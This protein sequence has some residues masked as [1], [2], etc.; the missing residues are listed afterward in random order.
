MLGLFRKRQS[1]KAF[2]GWDITSILSNYNI[3]ELIEL[4]KIFNQKAYDP[5]QIEKISKI[6]GFNIQEI[7]VFESISVDNMN[8]NILAYGNGLLIDVD[9]GINLEY[10]RVMDQE[11]PLQIIDE[12]FSF[13]K[14]QPMI[15]GN[16]SC[17]K[18]V[19]NPYWPKIQG[20][21]GERGVQIQ[22]VF[23]FYE[24]DIT[25]SLVN[26]KR[27]SAC[28]FRLTENGEATRIPNRFVDTH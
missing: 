22:H 7:A 8:Q 10:Y 11:P 1:L 12:A 28:L 25:V 13:I 2:R 9:A 20:M 17:S 15:I 23:R 6:L 5:E 4:Q 16:D 3:K 18:L 14:N 24:L 19:D 27:Q 21:M 26:S